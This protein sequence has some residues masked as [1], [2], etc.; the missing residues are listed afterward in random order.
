MRKGRSLSIAGGV[1]A[2]VSGMILSATPALAATSP[3]VYKDTAGAAAKCQFSTPKPFTA[4]LTCSLKDTGKDG[5]AVYVAFDSGYGG[6]RSIYNR[7]GNGS[8]YAFNATG[9]T[10]GARTWKW[11]VCRDRQAPWTD[12]CS[13]TYSW[14]RPPNP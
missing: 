6:W 14:T 9:G 7:N 2:A 1:V 8:V 5:D 13:A 12:N 4:K 3:V 11:K 10:D